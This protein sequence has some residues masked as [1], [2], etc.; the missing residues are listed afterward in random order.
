MGGKIG[1]DVE[2]FWTFSGINVKSWDSVGAWLHRGLL[3]MFLRAYWIGSDAFGWSIGALGIHDALLGIIVQ[4]VIQQNQ[5]A[6]IPP[7]SPN[8]LTPLKP[9]QNLKKKTT[10]KQTNKPNKKTNQTKQTKPTA[11]P[12]QPTNELH[13]PSASKFSRVSAAFSGCCLRAQAST[14]A[15]QLL[16]PPEALGLFCVSFCLYQDP[17]RDAFW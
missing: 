3:G 17:Q 6:E 10:R 4:E 13:K 14:R 12:N 1:C 8:H 2:V 15:Q 16:G 5:R 9:L 11:F 7:K